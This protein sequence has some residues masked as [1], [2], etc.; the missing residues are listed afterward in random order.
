LSTI[1]CVYTFYTHLSLLREIVVSSS[2]QF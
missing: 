1:K 2:C